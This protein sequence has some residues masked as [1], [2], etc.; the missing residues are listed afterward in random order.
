MVLVRGLA[1]VVVSW[2]MGEA[3]DEWLAPV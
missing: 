2:F 1:M 3:S